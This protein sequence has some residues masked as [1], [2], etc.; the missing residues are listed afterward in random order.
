MFGPTEVQVLLD[1]NLASP[2]SRRQRTLDLVMYW[3]VRGSTQEPVNH[4]L[5]SHQSKAPWDLKSI[6]VQ[7]LLQVN[8]QGL[9]RLPKR[10]LNTPS[11]SLNTVS[12]GKHTA[13]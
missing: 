2:S 5:V 8:A 11:L 13:S 12:N 4:L 7:P 6:S 3:S 1:K 10:S 9:W